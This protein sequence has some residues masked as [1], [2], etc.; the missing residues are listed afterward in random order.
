MEFLESIWDTKIQEM[1]QKR[2]HDSDEEEEETSSSKLTP[3][4]EK[5]WVQFE[6][7][8]FLCFLRNKDVFW[9]KFIL[10]N[11]DFI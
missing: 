3:K 10:S 1:S 9:E 2:K 6:L 7:K 8:I 5:V 4:K 11:F